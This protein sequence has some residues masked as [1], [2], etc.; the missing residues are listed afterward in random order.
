MARVF[1][2][3]VPSRVDA[4]TRALVPSVNIAP[5]TEFGEVVVMF[6]PRAPFFQTAELMR[7]I[8]NALH[9]YDA[10]KGDCIVLLGDTIL[11]AAAA[12]YLGRHKGKFKILR[13]DRNLGRYTPVVVK[14]L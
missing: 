13:W 7:Q 8:E 4:S 9:D 3:Q 6:P 1:V 14:T 12:A 10:E 11:M 5:A 2:T